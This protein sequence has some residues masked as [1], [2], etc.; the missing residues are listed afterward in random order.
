MTNPL[1]H[2]H[3]DDF[4]L[5]VT[6]I[7]Y[8]VDRPDD[9]TNVVRFLSDG[10]GVSYFISDHHDRR[11]KHPDLRSTH[12]FLQQLQASGAMAHPT[13]SSFSFS[14]MVLDAYRRMKNPSTTQI[15]CSIGTY[16][17]ERYAET[18]D[19][20]IQVPASEL[21]ESLNIDPGK[22]VFHVQLLCD[23]GLLQ[24]IGPLNSAATDFHV[25]FTQMGHAWAIR[26]FNEDEIGAGHITNVAVNVQVINVSRL[27][28]ELADVD[29]SDEVRDEVE[30][31]A[32]HLERE[33]TIE[34]AARLMGMVAKAHQLLPS[35]VRF[36]SDN[37]HV[38][39]H[40]P[41]P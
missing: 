9:F 41:R 30:S 14:P 11:G 25:Q 20:Y 24:D 18:G 38:L 5:A 10:K 15:L 27:V 34:K 39:T 32:R 36:A 19:P 26:G 1:A 2:L 33:P 37:A 7:G 16:L 12:A 40:L 21:A 29:V 22:A 8:I 3:G 6:M 35:I 23:V 4:D 28:R 31:L 13:H 17:H